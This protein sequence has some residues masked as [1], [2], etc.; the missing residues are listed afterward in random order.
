M[1][2][3]E[4]PNAPL[5]AGPG[6]GTT[7]RRQPADPP[8]SP[9]E[10]A[11]ALS[12]AATSRPAADA[13]KLWLPTQ[14]AAQPS[15]IDPA[16]PGSSQPKPPARSAA[17]SRGDAS[18]EPAT[19]LAVVSPGP[20]AV[21]PVVSEKNRAPETSG[22]PWPEDSSGAPAACGSEGGDEG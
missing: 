22:A 10:R 16:S 12:A 20:R 17:A 2:A 18:R 3:A 1:P 11:R 6:D 7:E 19:E 15:G 8:S 5:G 4:P 21:G 14:L 13:E 9:P